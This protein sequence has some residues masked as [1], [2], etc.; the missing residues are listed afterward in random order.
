MESVG[1]TLELLVVIIVTM[2]TYPASGIVI[3]F[4]YDIDP[5]HLGNPAVPVMRG[6]SVFIFC[7]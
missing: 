5:L 2:L 7:G 3:T 6:Y 1:E 4:Y